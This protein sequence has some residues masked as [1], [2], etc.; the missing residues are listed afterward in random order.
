MGYVILCS[1]VGRTLLLLACTYY[2]VRTAGTSESSIEMLI[3]CAV[4]FFVLKVDVR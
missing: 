4:M 3:A 1:I 2:F